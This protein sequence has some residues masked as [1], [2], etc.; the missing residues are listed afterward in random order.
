MKIHLIGI[1]GS[2]MHN[3]AIDLKQAWHTVSGSDK[4]IFD[5]AKSRLE[6]YGLL[7]SDIWRSEDNIT[8][9]ID[10]VILGMT[11]ADNNIE[12]LKAQ[13]L[14]LKVLSFPQFVYEHSKDKT[15][16]V[17][18]WSHGKTSTTSMICHVLQYD[19][20]DF[21]L[22]V[23]SQIPGWDKMV[24][25]SDADKIII[26]WDEYP[27][28]KIDL[29]PKFLVYKHDIW[30]LN[31][32]DRDHINIYDTLESYMDCFRKFVKQTPRDGVM[33]YYQDDDKVVQIIKESNI[34]N[35]IWYTIHP[36]IIENGI[37]YLITPTWQQIPLEIF[38]D[39]NMI[40]IS[41]AKCVC[42]RLGMSQDQFY[43]AIST[44]TWA[45]TRL[46][47]I[48][49]INKDNQKIVIFRD[50]AHSPSK[51]QAT[52]QA[53]RKQYPERKVIAIFELH[54]FST[55]TAEFM[56]EYKNHFDTPDQA[57]IYLSDHA[58]SLKKTELEK[59]WLH[60]AT[61][62]DI[63]WWFRREDIKIIRSAS[64]LVTYITN[65]DKS[66]TALLLMS[67]GNFD[68]LDIFKL[69]DSLAN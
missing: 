35:V 26:E 68:W 15:R 45:K 59:K 10:I 64:E 5:P 53:V 7:P 52:C 43:K 55:M 66:N 8:P 11:A 36:N 65:I 63:I 58:S 37:T 38:G 24:S 54:T 67:S 27:D 42:E 60:L 14:W 13:E 50:F 1:G 20:E 23:G 41:A 17:I 62:E 49:D 31:G 30:V 40:N 12:K 47:K 51:L 34:P 9:D 61:D 28:S 25:L 19:K 46:E 39:H 18:G 32:I 21:D 48:H 69:V 56:K 6:K 57:I 29:T 44:F 3:L 22:L 33:Y 2:I 4:E 16:V